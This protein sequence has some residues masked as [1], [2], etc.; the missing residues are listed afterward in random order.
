MLLV[1]MYVNFIC[2]SPE[3]FKTIDS[4]ETTTSGWFS[5]EDAWRKRGEITRLIR[6]TSEVAR[7]AGLVEPILPK[8]AESSMPMMK[9]ETER[10][11]KR[12]PPCLSKSLEDMKVT[13][14][15]EALKARG[16]PKSGKKSELVRRLQSSLEAETDPQPSS[17]A[18]PQK[19][20]LLFEMLPNKKPK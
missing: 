18:L 8:A 5:H 13:E 9:L 11:N 12:P 7:V 20:K 2:F 15:Q 16:L 4:I 19:R 3:K 14:L 6:Q 10:E 17:Q 1:K